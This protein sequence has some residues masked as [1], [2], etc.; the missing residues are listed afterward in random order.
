MGSGMAVSLL[1]AGFDVCGYDVS[2]AAM[3]RLV[4]Q[5]GRAA[6]TPAEAAEARISSSRWW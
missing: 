4:A 2:A 1:R 6:A 5:G 3:E